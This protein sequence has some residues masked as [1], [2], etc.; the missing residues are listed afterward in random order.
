MS[1]EWVGSVLAGTT[2]VGVVYLLGSLGEIYAERSGI[3]NLGLEG[4]M[5]LGA[6]TSFITTIAWGHAVAFFVAGV[7]GI[8][9]GLLLAFFTVSLRLN[10]IAVG[11][12][13]TMLGS[14]LSGF[15]AFPTTRKTI[16]RALNPE[17]PS[18]ALEA[19]SAPMLPSAPLPFLKDVPIA[20]PMLFNHNPVV[21]VSLILA[22]TMWFLLFRTSVGLKIRSVGENPGMADALGIN[23]FRIRYLTCMLSGAFSAMAGAYLILGFQPFWI[24][25]ITG[26]R[27][28]I[29]LSLII[30]S[31]WS[32]LRA[33]FGSLLFGG[34][35]VLQYR[36]QLFGFGAASPQ[37]VLMLPYAIAVITLSLLSIESF[38]KRISAPAALAKPYY[39]EE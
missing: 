6:A 24:E 38:R 21:Y 31:A 32:P 4:I 37:F 1:L 18:T 5:A 30:L 17:L 12:A 39:R 34:I 29:T 3:L 20:G 16:L 10:Q 22:P 25:G 14:G 7:L 2:S 8:L 26:G 9:M 35:E 33:V 13:I 15:I 36:L 19:Q 28:F 27:G 11:L 23:V